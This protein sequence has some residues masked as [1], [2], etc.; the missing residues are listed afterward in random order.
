MEKKFRRISLIF[1]LG[2]IIF[3]GIRFVYFYKKFNQNSSNNKEGE[4]LALTLQKDNGLVSEGE[5]LYNNE[6]EL[7]FRGKNVNNYLLY[8]N[9]LWRIVKVNTD[10]SV[11]LITDKPVS[12]LFYSSDSSDFLKSD[13]YNWLNKSK[14]NTG[15]FEDILSNKKKYLVPNTLCTDTLNNL[16][17]ITC[18]KKDNESYV[19]LLSV[20]DYLNSKDKDS[21]INNTDSIWTVNS[22]DSNTAWVISKGNLSNDS[23]NNIHGVKA[24]IT[25]NNS[26]GKI[27]GKGTLDNPYKIEKKSE[28]VKYNSYVK[29]DKDLY[30]VVEANDKYIKLVNNNLVNDQKARY[31]RYYTDDFDTNL[32]TSI[33][34]YLN[35]TYYNT[36]T[37]KKNLVDCNY[38]VGNYNKSYKD[39]YSKKVT[40]KVGLLSIAD[41]NDNDELT[42]YLLLNKYNNSISN[43]T[44]QTQTY[45]N[46]IRIAVCIDKNSK[47]KGN[48]TKDNPFELE[49]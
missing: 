6:G 43:I 41:L 7:I 37:Y 32:K 4:I 29:L 48:G 30:T 36:L 25:L 26:I 19:G 27:G 31:Y 5:G 21:Y 47:F 42:N 35:N 40:T 33:A 20:A 3:Y 39:I 9:I 11:L 34:Y 46:K 23:I 1:I 44:D 14:T 18:N 8:S 17:N 45:A 10:N 49:A 22:K 13:I 15:I 28:K 24:V 38:Y 12:N 2:C 16:N